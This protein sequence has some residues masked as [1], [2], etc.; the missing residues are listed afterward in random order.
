[1]TPPLCIARLLIFSPEGILQKCF[2]DLDSAFKGP[3]S[4][5]AMIKVFHSFLSQ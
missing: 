2:Q 3:C 4:N 1:M 5:M